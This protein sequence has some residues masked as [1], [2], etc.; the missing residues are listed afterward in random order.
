M[1]S[2][3]AVGAVAATGVVSV[4]LLRL[5]AAVA[6]PLLGMVLGLLMKGLIVGLVVA[7]AFFLYRVF[8]RRRDGAAA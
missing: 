6:A 3:K 8:R 1:G 2:M 4:L 7:A 5:L